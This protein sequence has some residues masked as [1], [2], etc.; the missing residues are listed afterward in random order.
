MGEGSALGF[1]VLF[2]SR[3]SHV[4]YFLMITSTMFATCFFLRYKSKDININ[5]YFNAFWEVE[6]IKESI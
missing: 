6:G 4:S 1:A 5:S 2:D 3:V